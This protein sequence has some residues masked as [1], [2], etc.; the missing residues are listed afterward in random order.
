MAHLH[1]I[2]LIQASCSHYMA[3]QE[4]YEILALNI[5]LHT[6]HLGGNIMRRRM[7]RYI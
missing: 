6:Y 1:H 4:Q 3:F 7:S 2:W 5:S